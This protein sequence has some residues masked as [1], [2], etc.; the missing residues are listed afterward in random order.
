[1]VVDN[2]FNIS[3]L[4]LDLSS[5]SFVLM[6]KPCCASS[7]IFSIVVCALLAEGALLQ[8][9]V[10]ACPSRYQCCIVAP[11][12]QWSRPVPSSLASPS[13]PGLV[14]ADSQ[15]RFYL[16]CCA[17]DRGGHDH[18]AVVFLFVLVASSGSL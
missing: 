14:R 15:R 4:S 17:D 2:L 3:F 9:G 5:T 6:L 11:G 7:I 12:R 1:M 16:C 18:D 13:S 10:A 8:F